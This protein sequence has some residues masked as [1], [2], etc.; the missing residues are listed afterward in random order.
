MLTEDI[1]S[2]LIAFRGRGLPFYNTGSL[3]LVQRVQSHEERL[4]N[5]E[6][7]EELNA[8]NVRFYFPKH[9]FS[10]KAAWDHLKKGCSCSREPWVNIQFANGVEG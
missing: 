2:H 8:P 5:G 3:S 1:F 7:V 4:R 9:W 6:E 10:K